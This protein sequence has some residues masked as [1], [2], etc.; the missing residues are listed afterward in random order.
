MFRKHFE[1]HKYFEFKGQYFK[2]LTVNWADGQR[3]FPV[4]VAVFT[5]LFSFSLPG[6]KEEVKAVLPEPNE[7]FLTNSVLRQHASVSAFEMPS[8]TSP[9]AANICCSSTFHTLLTPFFFFLLW[10]S[11][12]NKFTGQI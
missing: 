1:A 4:L 7:H 9:I 10:G 5:L 12:V 11:I 6:R 2:R 8:Y 3:M